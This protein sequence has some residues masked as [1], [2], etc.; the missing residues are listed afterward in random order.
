MINNRLK[1]SD[2]FSTHELSLSAAL[3]SW[4]FPLN[5]IDKTNPSRVVFIF[6]R[7]PELDNYIQS[8]WDNSGKISPKTYFNALREVKSRI[9]EGGTW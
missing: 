3:V 7:T 8:F 9:Y 1:T 6:M 4:G 2:I 5:C